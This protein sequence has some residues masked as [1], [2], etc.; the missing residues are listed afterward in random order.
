M[1]LQYKEGL[2]FLEKQDVNARKKFLANNKS[3]LK[4]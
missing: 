2:Q 3:Y 1:L 4:H